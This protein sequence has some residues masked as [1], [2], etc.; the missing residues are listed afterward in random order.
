MINGVDGLNILSDSPVRTSILSDSAYSNVLSF[1]EC[2]NTLL[3]GFTMGHTIESYC[4]GEV[5]TLNACD[6]VGIEKCRLFGCGILGISATGCSNLSSVYC[7]IFDCPGGAINLAHTDIFE[8]NDCVIHDCGIPT[9]MVDEKSKISINGNEY[10]AG[11]YT[12][13]S[14]NTSGG[15]AM[16]VTPEEALEFAKIIKQAAVKKDYE[17][18]ANRV[19]YPITVEGKT[20]DYASQLSR[21]LSLIFAEDFIDILKSDDLS[22]IQSGKHSFSFASG[23]ISF[24]QFNGELLICEILPPSVG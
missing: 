1:R 24:S 11:N 17:T 4:S 19:K 6:S 10:S 23:R 3:S 22:D 14:S 21:D 5:I 15:S 18:F 9:V 13:Q 8:L 12:I 7:E 16:W 20:Y 2:S